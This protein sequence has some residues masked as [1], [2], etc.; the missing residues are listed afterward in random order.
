MAGSSAEPRKWK[1]DNG[2]AFSPRMVERLELRV[3]S[4]VDF[5][6]GGLDESADLVDELC[7]PLPTMVICELLGA[8]YEDSADIRRMSKRLFTP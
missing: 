2:Q 1:R 7:S 8:P 5:L 3:Q 6:L 4:I